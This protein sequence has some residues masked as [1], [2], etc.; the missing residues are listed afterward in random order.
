[1]IAALR[2]FLFL[3]L[4]LVSAGLKS[5]IFV[6]CDTV[7][8]DPGLDGPYTPYLL[9]IEDYDL[10]AQFRFSLEFQELQLGSGDTVW[11][12]DREFPL[13]PPLAVLHSGS[14]ASTIN[15]LSGKIRIQFSSDSFD[16]ASGYRCVVKCFSPYSFQAQSSADSLCPQQTA[17]ISIQNTF[18]YPGEW[19]L[20]PTGGASLL[21]PNDSLAF[22]P[23]SFSQG[24]LLQ[25]VVQ[26]VDTAW[27]SLSDTLNVFV[28]ALEATPILSGPTQFCGETI[29]L[30][31]GNADSLLWFRNDTLL[32]IHSETLSTFLPGTYIA[33]ALDGCGSLASIPL[34]LELLSIPNK[35]EIS[36]EGVVELCAGDSLNLSASNLAPSFEWLLDGTMWNDSS[37]QIQFGGE[38]L[39]TL[40]NR[41]LCGTSEAD[42]VQVNSIAAPPTFGITA[43]GPIQFCEGQGVDLQVSQPV[44]ALLI[45]T[46]NGND[47]HVGDAQL[48]IQ[49]S[50]QFSASMSNVCGITWASDTLQLIMD[51][52]PEIPSLSAAGPTTLCEGN[53]VLL[54]ASSPVSTDQLL[55]FRNG[56]NTGLSGANFSAS[57]SGTYTVLAQNGCG[58]AEGLNSIPVQINPLPQIPLL[59]TQGNPYLCNGSSVL[60]ATAAQSNATWQ[61][62]RNGSIFPSQTNSITVTQPGVYSLVVSNSCGTAESPEPMGV[63]S[64]SA[65]V[66]PNIQTTGSTAFCEGLSVTL[67]T[68]PQNG[69]F[70][71]WLLDGQTSGLTGYQ[72]QATEA[73]NWSV[74][75]S[76]ACDTLYG[77]QTIPVTVFPLPPAA[78]IQ[79]SELLNRCDGDSA[80]LSIVPLPGVSYQWRQNGTPLS[81]NGPE[82]T[83]FEEGLYSLSLANSCGSTPATH[84]VYL[85]IDSI[86]PATPVLTA[87]PG[88]ALCPGGYVIL[89]AP[90]VSYMVYQWY[91]ND[92]LIS[93]SLNPSLI[94]TA[95][96]EYTL[97][98]TNACGNS[99]FSEGL[100]LGPGD[101]PTDFSIFSNADT[102]EFCENDSIQLSALVPFGV[103]VRWYLNGDSLLFGPSQVWAKAAGVYSADAWNGCGEAQG[104]NTLS[105]TQLP[106]PSTPVITL[107]N[108]QLQTDAIGSLQW[109]NSALQPITGATG[110][111]YNPP[112]QNATYFVESTGANGC[113]SISEPFNYVVNAV[114]N[115]PMPTLRVYPIPAHAWFVVDGLLRP[116]AMV[117]RDVQGRV[118]K[119]MN[120]TPGQVVDISELQPGLYLL[121]VEHQNFRVLI[122]R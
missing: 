68:P 71:E 30:Q 79:S 75:V 76:N 1:M 23:D 8:T 18:P 60:I 53:S 91:R 41:N 88:P 6:S 99:T 51:E 29:Q 77:S 108:T 96:G 55:W 65:P 111:T 85:N 80:T 83:I 114:S 101:P 15:A 26:P 120:G 56:Q 104:I 35:P 46:Q 121:E 117:L 90:P 42:S 17:W 39:I 86:A 70:I 37:V 11:I 9:T 5:Q 36:L 24:Q 84:T 73:G 109:L 19:Q 107:F 61:W 95:W 93:T 33:Q 105:L 10:P 69:V 72:V 34:S 102:L 12:T 97:Q 28:R 20:V 110:A 89:N 100:V 78:E 57:V 113:R 119:Q 31:A 87:Q 64:G 25:L 74:R 66:A 112:P 14:V 103:A 16:E 94:A 59:F 47:Y 63:Y 45:W 2:S 43:L 50:G 115:A 3:C 82:I 44:G 49:E 92:T 122:Q 22:Q 21:F 118:V 98:N 67:T 38:G 4:L 54:Q 40:Q 116:S 58:T 81:V 32:N 13:L 52:L 48:S 62:Y 27:Q 7:L 106:A